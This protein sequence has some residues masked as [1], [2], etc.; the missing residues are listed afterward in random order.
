MTSTNGG[1]DAQIPIIDISTPNDA[2]AAEL[3]AAASNYGFVFIKN[4]ET[5]ISSQS[6]SEMFAMVIC[7][8]IHQ[9]WLTD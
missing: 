6:I 2:V 5:V 8:R 7:S 4:N 9:L 1:T 3:L